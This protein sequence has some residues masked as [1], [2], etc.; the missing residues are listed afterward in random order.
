MTFAGAGSDWKSSAQLPLRIREQPPD[1]HPEPEAFGEIGTDLAEPRQIREAVRGRL[2]RQGR[3]GPDE[4]PLP[5]VAQ[6]VVG[7]QRIAR[8]DV[9]CGESLFAHRRLLRV[10]GHARA[11]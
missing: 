9:A 8:E 6:V 1:D 7:E 3:R 5:Q 10:A 4:A 11:S 2:P